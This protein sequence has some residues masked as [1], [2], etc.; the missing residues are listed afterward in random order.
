MQKTNIS[1][2]RINIHR[3]IQARTLSEKNIVNEFKSKKFTNQLLTYII[4]YKNKIL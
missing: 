2:I 3:I 4:K 1:N